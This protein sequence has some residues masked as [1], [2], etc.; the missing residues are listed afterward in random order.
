MLIVLDAVPTALVHWNVMPEQQLV[1]V[2]TP[3]A[4]WTQIQ[5]DQPTGSGFGAGEKSSLTIV[6]E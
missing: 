3:G 5:P 4:T 2:G 1:P 6:A